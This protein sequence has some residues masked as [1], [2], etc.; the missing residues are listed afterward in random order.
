MERFTKK[1]VEN[2]GPVRWASARNHTH[3]E[4]SNCARW[5]R[6]VRGA[7]KVS[8]AKLAKLVGVSRYTVSRWERKD[9]QF[10]RSHH[11]ARI[12]ILKEKRE[13]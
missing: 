12:R 10:P 4:Q 11:L 6:E 7:L 8:Q 13:K 1:A 5:I 9:G 3:P 2:S